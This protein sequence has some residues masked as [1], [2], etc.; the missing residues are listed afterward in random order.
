MDLSL[1]ELGSRWRPQRDMAALPK[2][3]GSLAPH[4]NDVA[5]LHPHLFRGPAFCQTLP[6]KVEGQ[7]APPES[8]GLTVAIHQRSQWLIL[9]RDRESKRYN[10]LYNKSK[11]YNKTNE[12]P[13]LEGPP[14]S[15][16]T[17]LFHLSLR[18]RPSP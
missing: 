2:R 8:L 17:C 4:F 10:I 1:S 14:S 5:M 3:E 7:F 15:A 11:R 12:H 9:P 18:Q 13:L 6:I 16:G